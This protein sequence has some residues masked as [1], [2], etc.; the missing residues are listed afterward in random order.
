MRN[1]SDN[2]F[3]A[4]TSFG[5]EW[6]NEVVISSGDIQ[7]TYTS[8]E[9][10][11]E[12]SMSDSDSLSMGKSF[13]KELKL[14][15]YSPLKTLSYNNS[16]IEVFSKLKVGEDFETVKMGIFYPSEVKTENDYFTLEIVAYDF[17]GK[18]QE[19]Y[20]PLVTLPTTPQDI[21]ED[22]ASQY[23]FNIESGY[24]YGTEQISTIYECSVAEM[25]GYMAGLKGENAIFNSE[26]TFVYRWYKNGTTWE[27]LGVL[28]W[29][30]LGVMT[31]A[32][33]DGRQDS[34][35][36][37]I[38]REEQ[39]EDGLDINEGTFTISSI[40]SGTEDNPLI[41][42][43]GRGISFVNPYMTQSI[44]NNIGSSTIGVSLYIG[45][46]ETFGNPMLEVG[47][48]IYVQD[49][50]GNYKE[51][52][53]ANISW[54]FTG[55]CSSTLYSVGNPDAEVEFSSESPI[56]KK[57]SNVRS[58]LQETRS[59]LSNII[60]TEQG[61]Y[62]IT[63][64]ENGVTTGWIIVDDPNNPRK[65]VKA[66]LGG[67][68]IGNQGLLGNFQ[69]AITGDGIVAD[70]IKVGKISADHLDITGTSSFYADEYTDAY[71]VVIMP[72]KG[73]MFNRESGYA[74]VVST[75]TYFIGGTY[76]DILFGTSDI[77]SQA[78]SIKTQVES[79]DNL[80]KPT[81]DGYIFLTGSGDSSNISVSKGNA[82]V[83]GWRPYNQE[84]RE[85]DEF[86]ELWNI[87]TNGD[88]K[89]HSID[90]QSMGGDGATIRLSDENGNTSLIINESSSVVA[91]E[92]WLVGSSTW[93][94]KLYSNGYIELMGQ[95][96]QVRCT[97]SAT[98]VSGLNEF[99]GTLYYPS[100]DGV[101]IFTEIPFVTATLRD[102]GVSPVAMGYVSPSQLSVGLHY[103]TTGST[104]N[105]QGFNV[106]I[107]GKT[108]MTWN[109]F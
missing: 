66:T 51:M 42:G 96:V 107:Y 13:C 9:I 18:L 64:D 45:E 78:T 14:K 57:I 27:D 94:Y 43:S 40:I 79:N 76:T 17:M 68:G 58:S 103:L 72:D 97:K 104:A 44:L 30:D 1:V 75:F 109:D 54:N 98:I 21:I 92:G 5:R 77:I 8:C 6:A 84:T 23:G 34:S 47:D 91:K 32:S 26:G 2:Y 25:L 90:L 59:Q 19:P 53:L 50:Q 31:W 61:I 106:R 93:R 20:N 108:N 67:I 86:R 60:N 99:S 52:F 105:D 71:G 55:G 38:S 95:L 12:E 65:V 39:R 3:S 33:L 28:T 87:S 46:V 11:I 81:T 83:G 48:K 101:P 16:Q 88:I 15:L 80:Y 69:T 73:N 102:V 100:V 62:S 37:D 35:P 10:E 56:E 49:K 4:V 63:T 70:A 36:R 29:E 89:A 22:I 41:V 82:I 74:Q 7:E 24:D 85:Y